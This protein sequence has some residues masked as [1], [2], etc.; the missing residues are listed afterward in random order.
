VLESL[1]SPVGWIEIPPIE[2]QDALEPSALEI[3]EQ[4]ARGI[5]ARERYP[6]IQTQREEIKEGSV[7]AH[8]D[9]PGGVIEGQTLA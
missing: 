9:R 7:V 8:E 4:L 3:A 1:A 6:A 2:I 5:V